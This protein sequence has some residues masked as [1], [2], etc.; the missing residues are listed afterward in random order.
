[1]KIVEA[2]AYSLPIICSAVYPYV[3]HTSNDG[4]IFATQNNWKASIQ[5]LIDAGASVRES[6]GKSNFEYCNTYHNLELHNL[7]RL[8]LYEKLCK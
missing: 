3:Y 7:T 8:A 4:V 2:A 6:M 5:K 1:L